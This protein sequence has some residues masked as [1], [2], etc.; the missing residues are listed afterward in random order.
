[1]TSPPD[2]RDLSPDQR[3][4]LDLLEQVAGLPRP[5]VED[6]LVPLIDEILPVL[7]ARGRAFRGEDHQLT[8]DDLYIH[9]SG[10]RRDGFELAADG[11]QILILRW[12]GEMEV[13]ASRN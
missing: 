4:L 2:P 13:L 3:E 1:M 9:E 10:L 11:L 8:I 12:H 5:I 6:D 7:D